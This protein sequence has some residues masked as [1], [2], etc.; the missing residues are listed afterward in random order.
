MALKKRPHPKFNRPNYGRS[1]R[2]RIKDNWRR[3]RGI[4]NKK[5]AKIKYMGASPSIGYG[6]PSKIKHMHPAGLQEVRVQS[7]AD[8]AGLK[9]VLIRIAGGVGRIKKDAIMKLATAAKLKVLNYKPAP[10]KAKK[11]K[12]GEK[13]QAVPVKQEEPKKLTV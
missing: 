10:P 8:M 4:D 5:R 3:Q 6:Q 13:K 1:S 2:S 7:P 9:N 11:E 12:K